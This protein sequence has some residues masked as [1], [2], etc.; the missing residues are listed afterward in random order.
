M[1]ERGV[2]ISQIVGAIPKSIVLKLLRRS[3]PSLATT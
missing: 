1:V 2:V 3:L